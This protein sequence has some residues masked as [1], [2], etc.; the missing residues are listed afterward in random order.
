M[1]RT[2][3]PFFLSVALALCMA[4]A[5]C[6]T[7]EPIALPARIVDVEVRYSEASLFSEPEL[8]RLVTEA[9]YSYQPIRSSSRPDAEER[10]K[11]KALQVQN[12]AYSDYAQSAPVRAEM[13]TR[14]R[15]AFIAA[16]VETAPSL[17]RP[18]ASPFPSR[19]PIT[20]A[21]E[22]PAVLEVDVSRLKI[23]VVSGEFS[24]SAAGKAGL[25]LLD[26]LGAMVGALE[27]TPVFVGTLTLRDRET[28]ARLASERI[29]ISPSSP[30]RAPYG[31]TDLPT[32]S[33]HILA[34]FAFKQRS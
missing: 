13:K 9:G 11:I 23:G 5:A 26:G 14:L 8:R 28:G 1:A 24:S 19:R 21:S 10:A 34:L 22:R 31:V 17:G 33:R 15:T 30:K 4:L 27:S 18:G 20:R 6:A 12:A 29:V 16:M 2:A 32:V 3:R 7:R 25:A